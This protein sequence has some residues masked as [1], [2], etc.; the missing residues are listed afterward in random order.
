MFAG[1]GDPQSF[2]PKIRKIRKAADKQVFDVIT[3]SQKA[4]LE[5]IKGAKLDISTA[6]LMGPGLVD[7]EGSGNVRHVGERHRRA[8]VPAQS[9]MPDRDLVPDLEQGGAGRRYGGLET[10]VPTA[11]KQ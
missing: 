5:K 7:F 4:S 6:L 3:I 1:R 10:V 9:A 11:A 8:D 2:D